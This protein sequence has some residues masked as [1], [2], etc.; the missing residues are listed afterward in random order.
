MTN[1]VIFRNGK[2]RHDPLDYPLSARVSCLNDVLIIAFS[3]GAPFFILELKFCWLDAAKRTR[4]P[5][6][7]CCFIWRF[8]C[9]RF[10]YQRAG[11]GDEN[12]APKKYVATLNFFVVRGTF[13]MD[14]PASILVV[15]CSPDKF[16]YQEQ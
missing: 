10:L 11:E 5:D 1:R 8:D 3:I 2:W 14:E 16:N 7:N 9:V 6:S 13:T 12:E 15:G 4:A